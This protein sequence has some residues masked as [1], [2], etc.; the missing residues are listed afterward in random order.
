MVDHYTKYLDSIDNFNT[1][2]FRNNLCKNEN[3]YY[4]IIK[5]ILYD[6]ENKWFLKYLSSNNKIDWYFVKKYIDRD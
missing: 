3:F 5:D 4:Y 6:N 2:M 1:Q